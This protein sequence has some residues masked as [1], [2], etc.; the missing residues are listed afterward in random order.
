MTSHLIHINYTMMIP[1]E[2][3]YTARWVG[4]YELTDGKM[5]R[6]LQRAFAATLHP[7]EA[8][9]PLLIPFFSAPFLLESWCELEYT[10]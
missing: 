6:L 4:F 3:A 7:P 9:A 10:S 1:T 8:A 5:H 2:A